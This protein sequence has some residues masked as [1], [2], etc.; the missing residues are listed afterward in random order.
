[1]LKKSKKA[2]NNT[3]LIYHIPLSKEGLQL[4]LASVDL[5]DNEYCYTEKMIHVP[6]GDCLLLPSTL[7]HSGHYGSRDNLRL[8]GVLSTGPW[9][10]TM[11]GY[12]KA[13]I[14]HRYNKAKIGDLKLTE[15]YDLENLCPLCFRRL[16]KFDHCLTPSICKLRSGREI[17]MNA[18]SGKLFFENYN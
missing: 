18:L 15:P 2:Q 4:R 10:F 11:L 14:K 16:G 7:L 3:A 6:F 5:V 1:M 9:V 12:L 17:G 13:F 8:H